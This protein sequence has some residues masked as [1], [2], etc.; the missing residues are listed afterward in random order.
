MIKKKD[1][2]NIII[3][4]VINMKAN[5][6]IMKKMVKAHIIISMGIN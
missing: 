6:I 5:F 4:M 2:E 3:T 1:M